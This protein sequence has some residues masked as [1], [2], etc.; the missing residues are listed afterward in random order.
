[1]QTL[2]KP[3]LTDGNLEASEG[4]PVPTGRQASSRHMEVAS[5][6]AGKPSGGVPVRGELVGTITGGED[7]PDAKPRRATRSR[8]TVRPGQPLEQ[9]TKPGS[10]PRTELSERLIVENQ[11]LA[12]AAAHKWARRCSRSF[13]DFIGPA[14]EGLINGCR[15]YDPERINPGTGRSYAISTCVCQFID[16]HIRH[17]IRD[18]GY[19][20]K[21]PSKWREYYPR[22]R[23]LLAEGRTLA[24]IVAAIPA[25][26]E[27]EI[28]EMMG[29]MVGSVALDDELTLFSDHQPEAHDDPLTP[30]LYSLTESA[31]NNLRPADRVL[32]ERWAAD[33]FGKV[34]YP[35]G[36]MTQFHNRLKAQLRGKTLVQYRQGVFGLDVP[37]VAPVPR[38]RRPRQPRPAPAS[39]VQPSLFSARRKPHPLAVKL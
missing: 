13:E 7:P 26:S 5:V 36:P 3:Q 35:G 2:P 24:Q 31:F 29:G 21:M 23:R 12:N 27:E 8:R 22:V 4:Q 37:T 39:A 33:P 25:F 38:E 20:V 9:P 6:L 19:D 11:G 16:G 1:M 18:Q 15:R 17:F 10:P 30:L 32:L 34:A 14:M 28:V